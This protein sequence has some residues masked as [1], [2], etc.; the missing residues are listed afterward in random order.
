MK[1]ILSL[2][3]VVLLAMGLVACSQQAEDP[4]TEPETPPATEA[5]ETAQEPVTNSAF[6][7][8][9]R[10]LEEVLAP[11][12]EKGTGVKIAAIESTLANSFW[13]TVKE[14]YEDAAKEWGV[15]ID[16]MATETETDTQGQ[17]EIM[18]TLL[19]KDYAAIAVS[20]LT[21]QNLIPG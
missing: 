2:L 14:G 1:K 11:L 3:I 16:V 7:E 9:N 20:P 4:G 13:L 19:V 21:Q 18:N 6:E 10:A 15:T 17:L 12:P 5:P 8:A